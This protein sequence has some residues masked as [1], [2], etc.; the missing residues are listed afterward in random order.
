MSL[1][2]DRSVAAKDGT[3]HENDRDIPMCRWC[4]VRDRVSESEKM[5]GSDCARVQFFL[6]EGMSDGSHC[7]PQNSKIVDI[8][9]LLMD[10]TRVDLLTLE[11][12]GIRVLQGRRD[13]ARGVEGSDHAF[14]QQIGD[15]DESHLLLQ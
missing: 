2:Y 15:G 6:N 10:D 3:V 7:G 5:F 8:L 14:D 1:W 12:D 9:K 4:V 11:K 13:S